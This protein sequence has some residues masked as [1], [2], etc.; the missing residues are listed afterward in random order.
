M[1]KSSISQLSACDSLPSKST[2]GERFPCSICD[3]ADAETP[4]RSASA[5]RVIPRYSRHTFS[6]DS[7][8]VNRLLKSWGN[9]SSPAAMAL[10]I[11][12]ASVMSSSSSRRSATVFHSAKG[13]TTYS[14][15]PS[16]SIIWGCRRGRVSTLYIVRS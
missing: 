6:G 5:A 8:E 16:C 14:G 13:I 9:V 7:P 11:L 2:L 4:Q 1:C 10:E 12:L 15:R 3:N